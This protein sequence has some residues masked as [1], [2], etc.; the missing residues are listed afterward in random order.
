[1]SAVPIP[2]LEGIAGPFKKITLH[3]DAVV[4]VHIVFQ[5]GV[6]VREILKRED[7]DEEKESK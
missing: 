2:C 1:M 6:I 5:L 7:G 4:C 3:G